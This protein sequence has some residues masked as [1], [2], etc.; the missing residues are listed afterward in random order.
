MSPRACSKKRPLPSRRRHSQLNFEALE[1]RKLLSATNI[2]LGVEVTETAIITA[3]DT[4]PRFVSQPTD[5]A[6]RSGNWSDPST[7]ADGTVPTR[8]DLVRVDEGVLVQ[9]D[10]VSEIDSLEIIGQLEFVTDQD[11][12]L[13]VTT[14]TVLPSGSLTIG[15]D[16]NPVADS[17]SVNIVFRDVALQTGTVD[18]PGIDPSQYGNGL[19]VFGEF[20]THGADKTPYIRAISDINRGD[21]SVTVESVPRDWRVG[22]RLLLPE[23][24]QTAIGRN[25]PVEL[26]ETEEVTISAINGNTIEFTTAVRFDHLGISDNPFEVERYA[27]IGNLT[28]NVVFQSEN[29]EGV[30][31]HVFLT[32]TAVVDVDNTSFIELGRTRAEFITNDTVIDESGQILRIGEN[33]G[34]RYSFHAH[35]LSTPFELSGSLVEDGWRWGITVHNTD[36]SLIDNNIV[37]E[38]AGAGIVTEAGTETGNVFTG[39]LVIKVEGGHQ[40][41]DQRGGVTRNQDELLGQITEIAVDGSAF[42]FRSTAGTIENN[43]VYD[44]AGY[45]YN[46]NGYYN[47]VNET[48]GLNVEQIDSFRNNEVASSFGGF[49]LTWSQGQSNIQENYQRQTFEDLLIWN[50]QTGVEAYHDGR[51]TLSDITIIGDAATSAA[52]E[53]S[54]FNPIARSTIGIDLSNPSYEN[55]DVVLDGVRVS[56]QNIGYAQSQNA[57]ENGTVLRDAVF[58]NYVN[59]LFLE[60]DHQDQLTTENVSFLESDVP[61]I[62]DSFPDTVANR[63]VVEDGAVEE[64]TLSDELPVAPSLPSD[65]SIRDGVLRITGSD[66]SDEITII[67]NGNDLVIISQGVETIISRDDVSSYLFRAGDGDDLFDNQ[68]SLPGTVLGGSGDDVLIGGS[69]IDSI[70]GEDGD[71][72]IFGG[73][74]DDLI[75]GDGGTD[76]I[77]GGDGADRIRG[78]DGNDTIDGGDG[79][80]LLLDGQGGNDVVRGGAGDDT[81]IGGSGND[82]V[83]GDAGDDR[84]SGGDGDDTIR[85]GN[86]DDTLRGDDGRDEVFG[87]AGIDRIRGGLGEDRLYVDLNDL[88][89]D[90]DDDEVIETDLEVAPESEGNETDLEVAPETEGNE[91]GLE[92]APETEGNETGLEV[93]PELM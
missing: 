3:N 84:V 56:G 37:Y 55:F 88:L 75:Y 91:T 7:W 63:F 23:T 57:G 81:V 35:H 5:I 73:D 78:G 46:F 89:L 90:T 50:T 86:G 54:A 58:S 80:D 15:T 38:A 9:F 30:R 13:L 45:G 36:D 19:L 42:W 33:Q 49:W 67:E 39:N 18:A 83:F 66:G 87:D 12:S 85:G 82:E 4:V 61:R 32:A 24:A 64:G 14:I 40:I 21:T 48:P 71:D 31:G 51:F 59:L 6:I 60:A 44:A 43:F 53:G 76:A 2:E 8:E 1:H 41:G 70:R 69:G 25:G 34:G 72:T 16:D 17:V 10:A 77:N 92:V 79:D 20:T 28:R 93:A 65:I 62:A 26:G 52:N 29:G 74:G 68:S 27:H 11:T 22:D 47:R